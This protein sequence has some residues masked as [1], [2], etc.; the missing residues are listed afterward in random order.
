MIESFVLKQVLGWKLQGEFPEVPQ[1][2]IVVA[3]HTSYWDAVIGKLF[4]R[5][6]GVKHKLLSKK[7]LFFFPANIVMYLIGAIPIRGVKNSNGILTVKRMFKEKKN[8][9]VVIC[10][11]GGFAKTEKWGAGFYY[12]ALKADVPIIVAYM[13]YSQKEVGVKGIITDLSSIDRVYQTLSVYYE[14]VSARYPENFVL[15]KFHKV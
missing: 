5:S 14:G 3:P 10:P 13:D 9:H 2:I 7:E 15:P 1:S 6:V 4:L 12:M 11:E 8:L